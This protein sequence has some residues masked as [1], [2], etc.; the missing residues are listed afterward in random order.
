MDRELVLSGLVLASAGPALL[1][2]AS[3]G[4]TAPT[5]VHLSERQCWRLLWIPALPAALILC[6]LLG[7]S[8]REPA[9]SEPLPWTLLVIGMLVTVV[10]CRA[11]IR[12]TRS[13]WSR[14]PRIYAA[15]IGFVRPRIV[16][17]SQLRAALDPAALHAVEAHE[18]A[19]ARHRDPLR[20]WLTQLV[21]DLQ[22]PLPNAQRRFHAWLKALEMTRDDEARRA[23]IDGADLAAAVITAAQFG[24]GH[25]AGARIT[26]E[27]RDLAERVDRLLQPLVSDAPAPFS[28]MRL[29]AMLPLF[30][31]AALAGARFGEIAIRTLLRILP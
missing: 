3:W 24:I 7:W 1:M 22:W 18:W 27:G 13:L 12:A 4:R 11:V 16:I 15:A 31:I 21:T 17:D 30:G 28:S 19:H 23:G 8:L 6:G 14:P 9:T 29:L 26:G 10:W 2:M 5:T 25:G 20:I